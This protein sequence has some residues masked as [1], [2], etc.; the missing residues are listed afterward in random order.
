MPAAGEDRSE[1]MIDL[2]GEPTGRMALLA[3]LWAS[4]RLLVMLARKDFFV[5]Y[6]RATFGVL[7][8]VGLPLLQAVVLAVVFSR[9]ARIHTHTSY[10]VFVFAGMVAWTFFSSTLTTAS[11]SIVDGSELSTKIYFPRALFPLVTLAA[12]LY[13]LAV[14]VVILGVMSAAFGAPVGAR[15][16]LL[17][18][19]IL[20]LVAL[21]AGFSLVLAALHVYFRDVRFLVQAALLGWF[22][23]TPVIY[24]IG[25]LHGL[26]PWL[27]A[28]P[29]TGLVELFRAATV[30]A[31]HGWLTSLWWSLGWTV[32][33]LALALA[34]HRRRDRVFVDLL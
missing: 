27:D 26:R 29:A 4:R 12:N 17:V 22:Y 19:A 2:A 5:R 11:T 31:D 16:L 30:G 3:D 28:N 7:W 34:L 33:L 1:P 20:V 32:A 25:L 21:T 10:A 9:V 14:T 8:A 13:G 23:L 6:R 24:P 18:P 15:T